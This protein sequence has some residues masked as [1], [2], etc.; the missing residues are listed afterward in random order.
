M[1]VASCT[2]GCSRWQAARRANEVYD[3]TSE[4]QIAGEHAQVAELLPWLVN[5]TLDAASAARVRAHLDDCAACRADFER[6]RELAAA[7]AAEGSLV[8]A[9]EPS[10][11]KLVARIEAARTLPASWPL[12]ESQP[13]AAA[14]ADLEQPL[15]RVEQAVRPAASGRLA[16]APSASLGRLARVLVRGRPRGTRT[17]TGGLRLTGALAAAVVV[18]A[19]AIGLMAWGGRGT[20]P[21]PAAAYRVLADPVS[22]P[23]R[24]LHARV[25][26]RPEVSLAQLDAM[27]SGVRAQIVDGP[28]AAGVYTL[29]FATPAGEG[30]DANARLAALRASAGVVFAEP[31]RGS[32]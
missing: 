5:G 18:E 11:Q 16:P 9:A 23:G 25:V 7:M 8:F 28:S 30:D 26:F 29:L 10:F 1:R 31:V 19:V 24:G 4:Q 6:E 32:P 22:L 17:R 13:R 2:A 14:A 27:L 15:D 12:D 21:Q 3:V 20:P